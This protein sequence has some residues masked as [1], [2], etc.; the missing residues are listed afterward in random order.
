MTSALLLNAIAF[1]ILGL[2][3]ISFMLM[4][5]K[6]EKYILW[7]ILFPPLVLM[8]VIVMP[9]VKAGALVDL[10]SFLGQALLFQVAAAAFAMGCKL[11]GQLGQTSFWLASIMNL[12][13]AGMLIAYY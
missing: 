12:G 5:D 2:Q 11:K 1:L 9:V 13:S 7:P 8:Y 10:T 4:R 3:L 6:Q